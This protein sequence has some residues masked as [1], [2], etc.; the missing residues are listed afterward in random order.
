MVAKTNWTEEM[1]LKLLRLAY[2]GFIGDGLVEEMGLT[3]AVIHRRIFEMG[4]GLRKIR[5]L[6]RDGKTLS[7]VQDMRRRP[8]E[9]SEPKPFALVSA[10][11]RPQTLMGI[12][13]AIFDSLEVLRDAFSRFEEWEASNKASIIAPELNLEEA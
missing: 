13:G 7:E 1:D 3:E 5:Q 10:S 2:S 9:K 8:G 6:K 12:L 11:D 4:M